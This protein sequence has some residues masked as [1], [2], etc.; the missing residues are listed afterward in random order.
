MKIYGFKITIFFFLLFSFFVFF[1]SFVNVTAQTP[2]PTVSS[3]TSDALEKKKQLIKELEI[4]LGELRAQSKTLASQIEV[5]N[6][7]IKLTELRINATEEELASLSED[8]EVTDKKISKLEIFLRDLTKVLFNRIVATYQVGSAQ[9]FQI[10]LSSGTISDF[11]TRANYLRIVQ[12]HD[13]K[14]IYETQQARD[15]YANQKQ[16]FEDKKKKAELLKKQLENYTLQLDRDKKDKENLLTITKNSESEY[17]RRLADALRELKQIQQAAA[18]L[19]TTEPK[20]IKRGDPI[21]I[22]GNTGY[23]FGPHLHFGVYNVSSLEEYDYYSLSENPANV[24]ELKSVDWETECS[25]DPK[26]NVTT[27][28]GSFLWPM[29]TDN[30]HITQGFGRTCYSDVYYRGNPHPAYDMYNN[31][32]RIVRAAEDGQAYICR[33]CTGDGGNGVFIVHPNGKMTLYWHLE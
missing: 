33:N 5:M 31:F 21:G 26:G 15:D 1:K 17:Q 20:K 25:G 27:G 22:M 10:L 16:I 19:I 29:S 12:V 13:K 30:L 11:F 24:L 7:Q 14:L 8:I 23:S 3:T 6:N 2:T 4:K 28:S 18:F 9:P 32:D